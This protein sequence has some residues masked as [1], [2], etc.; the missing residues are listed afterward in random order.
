MQWP[1]YYQLSTA[2]DIYKRPAKWPA[3]LLLPGERAIFGT[4]MPD[5]ALQKIGFLLS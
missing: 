2:D 1:V 3:L 5:L 4:I